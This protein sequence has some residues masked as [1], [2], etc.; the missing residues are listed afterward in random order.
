MQQHKPIN[1]VE[2]SAG[3][4]LVE[5]L[6]VIVILSILSAL[7]L[8]G[9]QSARAS[10]RSAKTQ[11]TIRK[12]SEMILPYYELYET[13]RPDIPRE[14]EKTSRALVRGAN[15]M[16][17][18]RLMTMELPERPA[19]ILGSFNPRPIFSTGSS[20][21]EVPPVTKR[22]RSIIAGKS[23]VSSS[24]LLHMI[25]MRG[26][27]ADPD[28]TS[29]FRP[30]EIGDP[31]QN[32]LPEFLDGWNNPIRFLRWPVG[33]S[34]PLQQIDGQLDLVDERV[35]TNGQRLVPLIYSAG[36]DGEYDIADF[37]ADYWAAEYDPF[38]PSIVK[39]FQPG[40]GGGEVV[41]YEVARPSAANTYIAVRANDSGA[42]QT[43]Q[44]PDTFGAISGGPIQTLGSERS[45]SPASVRSRDNIHN[46]NMSR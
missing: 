46:H 43:P 22:Y 27:A 19:D 31:N 40:G 15:R 32:G 21:T 41:L 4:T 3:F 16:A 12:L 13:R 28:Y 35:S 30:D 18:R 23:N 1:W 44:S 8:S 45:L 20:L 17:L 24:D 7:A 5:L 10:G 2:P 37:Q 14:V 11:S 33:F 34:S 26:V 29:H 25:V 9:I 36:P 42:T 38:H 39:H 6:V